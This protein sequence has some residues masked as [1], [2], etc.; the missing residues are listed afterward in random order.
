MIYA[1]DFD[2][3][4]CEDRFPEIGN[5]HTGRIEAVK[6]LQNLGHKV[7]LWTCRN[8]QPLIDAVEWCLAQGLQFDAVNENLPEVREK[9]G[10]DTRKVY[11]DKYIDDKNLPEIYLDYAH[12]MLL[13]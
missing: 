3:T 12:D 4:L 13:T 6:Q 10:G 2:G 11:C 1:V 5:P 7:I 8:G 9:W